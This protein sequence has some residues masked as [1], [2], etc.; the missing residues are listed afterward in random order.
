MIY[1]ENVVINNH[2]IKQ[3]LSGSVILILNMVC[4]DIFVQ[5]Y[6]KDECTVR[7]FLEQ[8][9]LRQ[10]H[11]LVDA[12]VPH[13]GRVQRARALLVHVLGHHGHPVGEALGPAAASGSAGASRPRLRVTAAPWQPRFLKKR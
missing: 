11:L 12:V 13:V 5:L 10:R 2:Q 4:L 1:D 3:I 7:T 9:L 6:N 8:L